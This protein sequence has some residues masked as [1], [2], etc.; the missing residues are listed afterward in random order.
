M[1]KQ[2]FW[3]FHLKS[4][5]TTQFLTEKVINALITQ[6]KDMSQISFVQKIES[7]NQFWINYKN[8]VTDFHVAVLSKENSSAMVN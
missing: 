6:L 3:L 8:L 4:F 7:I 2:P 5:R 1:R